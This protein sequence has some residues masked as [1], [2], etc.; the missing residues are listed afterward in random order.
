MHRFSCLPLCGLFLAF[1]LVTGAD[2]DPV[3][4]K[5]EKAKSTYGRDLENFQK[6][7]G[8][9]LDKGEAAARKDGNKKLVDNIK[10]DRKQFEEKG[11][12]PKSTPAA[13]RHKA[14][15]ALAKMEAAFE[16]AI[17]EYTKTKM[18]DEATKVTKEF[19][20]YKRR[21]QHYAG[22]LDAFQ[23]DSV[24]KGSQ[25]VIKGNPKAKQENLELQVVERD[26]KSFK[27]TLVY[28]TTQADGEG[29]I[30]KDKIEW[31]RKIHPKKGKD[32]TIDYVAVIKQDKIYLECTNNSNGQVARGILSLAPD[33]K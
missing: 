20:A 24:W 27:A 2:E 4:A 23:V 3:R 11:Q 28:G 31:Q 16:L 5:L 22:T 17:K 10:A 29:T 13:I 12:L 6:A 18:D 9:Y 8:D 19:E 21:T 26:G 32:F 33:K 1:A 15:A 25:L 7:V 14:A 30:E